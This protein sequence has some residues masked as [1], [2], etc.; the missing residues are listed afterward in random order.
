MKDP[1]D[2]KFTTSLLFRNTF[3]SFWW[4]I[5]G[6]DQMYKMFILQESN[7]YITRDTEGFIMADCKEA[8]NLEVFHDAYEA[9]YTANFDQVDGD[10]NNS[11]DVIFHNLRSINGCSF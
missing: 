2:A 7:Q 1:S 9:K 4:C 6:F 11:E 3:S 10:S 8:D 5:L